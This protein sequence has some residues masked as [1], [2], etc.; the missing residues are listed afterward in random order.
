MPY[1]TLHGMLHYYF[2]LLFITLHIHKNPYFLPLLYHSSFFFTSE[3]EAIGVENFC[4][5]IGKNKKKFPWK[6]RNKKEK[7]KEIFVSFTQR[8]Q[9]S[10]RLFFLLLT[11]FLNTFTD[12][13]PYHSMIWIF[14]DWGNREEK[15]MFINYGYHVIE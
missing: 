4:A 15:N 5:S 7:L 2:F 12:V 13:T 8:I 11:H 10:F 3:V 6:S 1:I 9:E 14:Y